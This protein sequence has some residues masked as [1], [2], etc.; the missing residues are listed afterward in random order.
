V[1]LIHT[2]ECITINLC[3]FKFGRS[4]NLSTR[5][6]QYPKGSN[7]EFIMSCINSKVCETEILKLL[8]LK[9]KQATLYGSEY[10]EGDK[11]AIIAVIYNYLINY[12]VKS[13]GVGGSSGEG[14]SSVVGGEGVVGGGRIVNNVHNT[15]CPKCNIKFKYKSLLIRHL[16][17]SSRCKTS[18]EEINN[19]IN[20]INIINANIIP[21][22]KNISCSYC[23]S[24]FTKKSSLTYHNINSHCGKLNIAKSIMNKDGIDKLSLEQLKLLYPN[25]I[26]ELLQ[27]IK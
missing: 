1:Y 17:L 22:T 19:I 9:F 21:I 13:D 8:K 11:K 23:N 15:T 26:H 14:G 18:E 24:I 25:K 3:V 2:R 27:S 12:D 16:T 6:R 5:I 10:F 20:N 7:I 4:C